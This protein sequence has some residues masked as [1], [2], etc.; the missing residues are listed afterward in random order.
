MPDRKIDHS[1]DPMC[2]HLDQAEDMTLDTASRASGRAAQL[3]LLRAIAVYTVVGLAAGLFYREFTKANGYPEGLMGQ[4]GLAHTHILTLGLIV[5]LIVLALEKVFV[6]SASRLFRWF[7][8]IYNS[9]VVLTGAMLVWHGMLQVQDLESSKMIA[10]IAGVG[11]MLVGA[12][13]VLLLLSLRTAIRRTPIAQE[14]VL[15]DS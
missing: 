9:G 8:W 10:G 7:F 11:H 14:P 4:L 6:L 15:Q 1:M 2:E 3:L 13:L 5:L 12:G